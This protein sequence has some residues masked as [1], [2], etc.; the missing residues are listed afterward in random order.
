MRGRAWRAP[1]P[2]FSCQGASRA[3]RPARG[4]SS[5]AGPTP[6]T[7]GRGRSG[8][9][10][11]ERPLAA[12]GIRSAEQEALLLQQLVR[13]AHRA[14]VL[15]ARRTAARKALVVV[16]LEVAAIGASLDD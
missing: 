5:G 7:S 13:P 15:E 14:G 1:P 16:D 11:I 4:G 3:A 10:R 12:D 6:R 8:A 2:R 9:R